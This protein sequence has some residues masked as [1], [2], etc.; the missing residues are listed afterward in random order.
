MLIATNLKK[1]FGQ[2]SALDD[3]SMRVE[4]G[5]IV[6]VLGPNGA[7]KSTMIRILAGVLKPDSGNATINQ[8][9]IHKNVP[10]TKP[11]IGYLPEGAPQYRQLTPRQSIEFALR[12]TGWQASNSQSRT[13]EVLNLLDLL[14]QSN[15]LISRL[16]KGYQR[17]TALAIA[18]ATD[19]KVLLLDEPFDG[20]DPIQK[21]VGRQ[22]LR[23]AARSK[24]ILICT[25][26]LT[27]AKALCDRVLVLN[28]GQLVAAG[29][30]DE[31]LSQTSTS[32]FDQAFY[33]LVQA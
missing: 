23:Q 25:H 31:I 7:G 30:I 11:N 9:N 13:E 19:P 20:F 2:I 22:I 21:T 5:E 33:K 10:Q 15:V 29:T 16:S 27:E 14:G 17:R 1:Q 18:L 3:I 8:I 26:S 12:F 6:G 24:A 32:S 4:K 28:Q